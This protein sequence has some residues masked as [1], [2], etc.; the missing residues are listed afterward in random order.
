MDIDKI[1]EQII[2]LVSVPIS[3]IN[4]L[5]NGDYS[6]LIYIVLGSFA[7]SKFFKLN[8]KVDTKRK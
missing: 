2:N 4:R 5:F 1:L 3:W 6:K 7:L 8:V